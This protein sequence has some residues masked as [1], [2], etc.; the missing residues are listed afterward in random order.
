MP[1]RALRLGTF[2]APRMR[3][4]YERAA[5]AVGAELV[6]G[7]AF[8]E[9]QDG[10]LDAAFLCGLPYVEQSGLE[11]LVAPAMGRADPVYW[12]DVV[13]RP[14]EEATAIE[15]FAGRRLAVNEPDSHSGWG[16]V[17]ATLARRGVPVGRFA[18]VRPTG[19]HA[20][21]LAAVAAGEVDVAAIDSHLHAA[22][23][24]DGLTVVERLGPSPSQ[25]LAAGPSLAPAERERIRAVL[26]G[27][28]ADDLGMTWV[29]VDD[30][31]YDPIRAMRAA[32][33]D[34]GGF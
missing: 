32:A 16:V 25:P 7:N 6:D 20:A 17:L 12:S 28:D 2:L 10:T 19:S 26:T 30:A 22:L 18:E 34:R 13:A 5:E 33:V 21:S 31:S 8:S 15:D 23:G 29:A 24:D 11:P 3:P 9:L 27:L 1:E 4:L 14:G